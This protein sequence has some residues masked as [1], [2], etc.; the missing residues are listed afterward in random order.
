MTKSASETGRIIANGSLDESLK[1]LHDIASNENDSDATRDLDSI[2]A[3][4][5]L[6]KQY[7]LNAAEDV[8]RSQIYGSLK[9]K[10]FEVFSKLSFAETV[11]NN[12]TLREARKRLTDNPVTLDEIGN[13][14]EW[15]AQEMVVCSLSADDN[16]KSRKLQ[17]DLSEC[18]KKLFDFLLTTC[19]LS[20]S[21]EEKA[22]K[23]LSSSYTDASVT[24]IAVSAMMLAQQFFFDIR[25]FNVLARLCVENDNE[26]LR[27][28][29]LVALVIA[30]PGQSASEIYND[31]IEKT[32]KRL[33]TLPY[34]KEELAELQAQ[35]ILCTDT[36]ENNKTIA[37]EI[38]PSIKESAALLQAKKTEQEM[39]DELLHPDK[40]ES[41]MDKVEKSI[42]K[43]RNMQKQ[44]AD[45]FFGGFSQAKRFSF[46][47][48]LV[49]WF[50]PFTIE[51]PQIA[52]VN[53]GNIPKDKLGRILDM[54][55]LCNSDKYSFCLTLSMV[56]SQI[57]KEVVDVI[58]KGEAIMGFEEQHTKDNSFTRLMYL[59]DIYRFHKLFHRKSD[60]TDPFASDDGVVF[61]N[62]DKVANLFLGTDTPYKIA[63]QLLGRN[64][65]SALNRLLDNNRDE[66]NPSYLKLKALS[67]YKQRHY[68]S[69]VYWF[70]KARLLEPDNKILLKR[71]ADAC[72]LAGDFDMAEELY[73][74]Y[75]KANTEAGDMDF[76]NYRLSICHLKNGKTDAAKAILFRLHFEHEDNNTYKSALALAHIMDDDNEKA[77]SMYERIKDTERTEQDRIRMAIVLW[78]MSRKEKAVKELRKHI[79]S[80]NVSQSDLYA[81]MNNEV[82]ECHSKIDDTELKIL[83]DIVYDHTMEMN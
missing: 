32:F 64:R 66:L 15:I 56:Y 47:Y 43:I 26:E 53:T 54:Q 67:E 7:A 24:R 14:L 17:E 37:N 45:I 68:H 16:S 3:T 57:P 44:G 51:H 34:I 39:L 4:Y 73:A 18:H 25:K 79:A 40:E 42:E 1:L 27:Q 81:K 70:E 61:F 60:F 80:N 19:P 38:I 12:A 23:I 31:E 63:R 30:R 21:E 52:S 76:E 50:L 71:T 9:T 82:S 46:F 78:T 36:E 33:E 74:D 22:Y 6:M 20:Q 11:R 29:A 5:R 2:A 8:Q 72:F 41:S 49:N 28:Y 55:P 58:S 62:W 10:T 83:V 35:M 77:V 75:I 59:Q 48:T 65:F 69:A 13:R